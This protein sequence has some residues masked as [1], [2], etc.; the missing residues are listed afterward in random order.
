[1][2]PRPVPADKERCCVLNCPS[3]HSVKSHRFPSDKT[4]GSAWIKFSGNVNLP[5]LKYEEIY[6]SGYVICHCHFK[7]SD[8]QCGVKRQ[9]KEGVVPSLFLPENSK[10]NVCVGQCGDEG[11]DLENDENSTALINVTSPPKNFSL[12]TFRNKLPETPENDS[13][14][15]SSFVLS[16]K[17]TNFTSGGIIT[18]TPKRSKSVISSCIWKEIFN[19]NCVEKSENMMKVDLGSFQPSSSTFSQEEYLQKKTISENV[20][21]VESE[22]EK[23]EGAYKLQSRANKR[24]IW[25]KTNLDDKTLKMYE[26]VLQAKKERYNYK[27]KCKRYFCLYT[28]KYF[29]FK[30]KYTKKF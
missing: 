10:A 25:K 22:T 19:A 16:P 26:H 9:L 17:M 15:Q 2:K 18:S 24:T 1:M 12:I 13:C 3:N 6:G 27:R 29:D 11:I 8:Y 7:A 5:Y 28:I 14:R 30:T 4:T 20:R 21:V 23:G